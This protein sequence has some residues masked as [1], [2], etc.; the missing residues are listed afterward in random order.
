LDEDQ[1]ASDLG[2]NSLLLEQRVG[3]AAEMKSP[4]VPSERNSRAWYVIGRAPISNAFGATSCCKT[5]PSS[6]WENNT[7][8]AAASGRYTGQLL[9]SSMLAE[10]QHRP[11]E[12]AWEGSKTRYVGEEQ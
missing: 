12:R 2:W 10:A 3:L 11:M 1:R 9:T 5:W 4:S 6:A 7:V 8:T